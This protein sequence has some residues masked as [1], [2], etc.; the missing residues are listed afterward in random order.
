[1]AEAASPTGALDESAE[2]DRLRAR[3]LPGVP[4]VAGIFVASALSYVVLKVV[5]DALKAGPTP[6]MSMGTVILGAWIATA[7][8]LAGGRPLDRIS[9][10]T[11]RA[12]LLM[13]IS[14][15][16]AFLFWLVFAGALHYSMATWT[17]PVVATLWFFMA[18][19]S[20]IGEEALAP[21]ISEG[22][23]A[24]LNLAVWLGA[25]LL[26]L[27]TVVWV[28]PF[29]F[30]VVETLLV[31]GGF[32][33]F[34]RGVRQPGKS[35]FSWAIL[36]LGTGVAILVSIALGQWTAGAGIGLW[37]IGM[38]SASWGVFFGLWAGLN[39]SVLGCLQCWPF[40]LVRQP[41]GTVV[42]F[43]AVVAWCVAIAAIAIGLLQ[44]VYGSLA[45]AQVEATVWAWHTLFWGF[46]FVL[47][48]G[49]GSKPYLWAGQRTPGVWE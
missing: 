31:T 41:W 13:A 24:I 46:C 45:T 43:L 44:S 10:T 17:F 7:F 35:V 30:G 36:A 27:K 18:A 1:M 14:L 6:F 9:S 33:Y 16:I 37:A 28:P 25:T 3:P 2:R 29:W 38:P 8:A 48:F 5:F 49:V 15:V 39:F 47:L 40:S 19:T 23:R 22:R 42:A 4:W 21:G 11:T 12:A 34:L 32:A 26:V 20:F